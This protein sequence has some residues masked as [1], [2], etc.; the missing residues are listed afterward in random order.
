MV[1][2]TILVRERGKVSLIKRGV[3]EKKCF[4]LFFWYIYDRTVIN[5]ISWILGKINL[6]KDLQFSTSRA[7]HTGMNPQANQ[8]EG[9]SVIHT[10]NIPKY[11]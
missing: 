9:V 6:E 11:H 4:L 8:S 2:L 10:R 3:E 7:I 1:L 5:K